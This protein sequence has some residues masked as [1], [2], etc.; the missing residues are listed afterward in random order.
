MTSSTSSHAADLDYLR[1]LLAIIDKADPAK[2]D[3]KNNVHA[4]AAAEFDTGGHGYPGVAASFSAPFD[5]L[6]V[7]P[8]H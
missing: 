1:R 7:F 6:Y 8:K 5:D 4:Y 2:A 3:D